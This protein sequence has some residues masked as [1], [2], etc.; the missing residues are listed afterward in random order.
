MT[1]SANLQL[2]ADLHHLRAGEG[3][4]VVASLR[5]YKGLTSAF[6][7]YGGQPPWLASAWHNRTNL[8]ISTFSGV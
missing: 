5:R 8:G 7:V 3:K 2:M 6:R 4:R 1:S